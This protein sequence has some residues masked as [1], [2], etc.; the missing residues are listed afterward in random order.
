MP[1]SKIKQ[2]S[3]EEREVH[4]WTQRTP[5]EVVNAAQAR[6]MKDPDT[7]H[8]GLNKIGRLVTYL[9]REYGRGNLNVEKK[10]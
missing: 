3:I 9:L 6:A 4:A 7:Q 5:L 2:P 8:L 10:P 1:K